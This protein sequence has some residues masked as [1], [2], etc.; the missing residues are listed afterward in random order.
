M[1]QTHPAVDLELIQKGYYPK[2]IVGQ[3]LE[4]LWR[5]TLTR[6]PYHVHLRKKPVKSR[7]KINY[8]IPNKDGEYGLY[9]WGQEKRDWGLIEPMP[10]E[11][12]V[13]VN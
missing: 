9:R 10:A 11:L 7:P 2:F 5:Y 1:A 4:D 6:T 8:G 12:L 13:V 3:L